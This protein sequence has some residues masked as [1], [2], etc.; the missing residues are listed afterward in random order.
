MN[1]AM[2][3]WQQ[4]R[5]VER[6]TNKRLQWIINMT[7]E[8]Q[9]RAYLAK[10]R[11]GIGHPP[12]EIPE[13]WAILLD[14]LPDAMRS[15]RGEP[16]RAEWAIYTSLTLFALH[17]QGRDMRHEPMHAERIGLGYAAWQLTEGKEEERERVARRFNLV[18][19]AGSMEEMT[20]Y[21][22][23]LVQLLRAKRIALDYAMLAGDLYRYQ[24]ED[25][26]GAVRL[27]WGQDFYTVAKDAAKD[28]EDASDA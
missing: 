17:Q 14:G 18:A 7:N 12:G 24:Y 3:R 15:D 21:L 16:T 26:A 25:L 10:L 9:Q 1:E 11:R 4:E 20:H 28:E 6:E 13:L 2:N 5:A 23:G 8:A 27:K 22:R 19:L